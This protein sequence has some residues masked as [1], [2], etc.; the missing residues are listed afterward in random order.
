M[1]IDYEVLESCL[2]KDRLNKYLLLTNNDKEKAV[3][4]YENNIEVS[5]NLYPLL[6]HF[7]I[8]LRNYCN[9]KLIKEIGE[10]W[11]LSNI[12]DGENKE[13]GKWAVNEVLK[14]KNKIKKNN[15]TNGDVVASLEFGFW[16]NLF[17]A[18][19]RDTIWNTYLKYIFK[20]FKRNE[21]FNI[22][23][24]I[25]KLRNRIFHYEP[26]IFD[27][28]LEEKYK[29]ILDLLK[30]MTTTEMFEYIIKNSDAPLNQ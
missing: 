23:D 1:P 29:N 24:N 6:N 10:N 22:L 18:N 4:S 8:I 15:I 28:Q 21:L 9:S 2:S 19:Y 5:K 7:E 16:S 12:L 13:K 14:V 11:Y 20:D 25:R 27:K 17:V 26:I 30:H 3:L